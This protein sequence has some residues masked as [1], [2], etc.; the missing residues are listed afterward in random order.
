M[1]VDNTIERPTR[2]QKTVLPVV[3][4]DNV[5]KVFPNGKLALSHITL[6]INSGEFISLVGPSGCGKSTVLKL[7]TGVIAGTSGKVSVLGNDPITTRR[8]SSGVSMVFQDSTLMPWRS[9]RKNVE[10]PLELRGVLPKERRLRSDAALHKVGLADVSESLPRQLSGGMRMRVAIARALVSEPRILLMDEP[11][12]ALDEITRQHLHQELVNL[13][14][15][16]K[17]T[18]IFVTHNVFEAAF[19]STRVLVMGNTGTIIDEISITEPA[20]R[21][22]DFRSSTQFAGIVGDILSS[23]KKGK[24]Q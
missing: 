3:E 7:V 12:G 10:L 6:N 23:L 4:L 8:K 21:P 16:M 20:P 5:S 24:S 19:L 15:S 2:S 11:F 13:W 18:I 17:T 9:V 14:T 22:E 1:S